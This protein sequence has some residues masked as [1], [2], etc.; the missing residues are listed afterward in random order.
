MEAISQTLVSNV[1]LKLVPSLLVFL[2]AALKLGQK[3]QKVQ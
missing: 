2:K 1:S 3:E